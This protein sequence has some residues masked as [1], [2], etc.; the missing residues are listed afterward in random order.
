VRS[1]AIALLAATLLAGCMIVDHQ[2]RR[3]IFMPTRD[4][5]APG[6]D[7]ALGMREIWIDYLSDHPEQRGQPVRLHGLW[8]PRSE[9]DAP[10]L[11]FLHGVRW[12]VH[13]SAPRM[14]QLHA[15]GFSVLS[16]DYRGFGLSSDALPSE[17]LASEDALAAWRWLAHRHPQVR[18][19][20]FGH[21]LGASLA[22]DLAH[23][24]DDE[25][26][27]IV[28]GAF[29]SAA[30]VLRS[31]WWGWLPVYALMTQHFDAARRVADIGS[32]LLVVHGSADEMV[33]PRL[34]RELYERARPPKRFVLVDGGEHEN[35]DV[36]GQSQYRR[37]VRELFGLHVRR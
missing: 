26:G 3:W 23:A 21:S 2:Q 9:S 25:A 6:L 37:A 17:T 22:I 15:L 4:T 10:V 31:T 14:R 29:T 20:V 13:A 35:T 19:F 1:L 16:I 7:A 12:T 24:V 5:W 33:A 27:V 11:L 8:L 18:R 30:D 34:G 36:V 32:P 28:E